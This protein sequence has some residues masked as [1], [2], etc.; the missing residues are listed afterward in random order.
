M[1]LV[2]IADR[3]TEQDRDGITAVLQAHG[4]AIGWWHWF[5]DAWLI[6]DVRGRHPEWWLNQFR[7]V[8]PSGRLL[9][10]GDGP[11]HPWAGQGP[12]EMFIPWLDQVWRQ[13][14]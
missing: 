3:L 13:R 14:P 1:R 8:A 6:R 7:G 9:V 4:D 2:V 12:P 5:Q 11:D 10:L